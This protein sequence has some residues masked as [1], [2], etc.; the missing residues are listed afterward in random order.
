MSFETAKSIGTFEVD[1]E[2]TSDDTSHMGSSEHNREN[3][4][5]VK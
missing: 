5:C 1:T 2:K 3:F 4:E